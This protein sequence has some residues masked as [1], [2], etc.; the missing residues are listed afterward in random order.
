MKT[1]IA[2]A[3]L[4]L[5]VATN[6]GVDSNYW[7]IEA[8]QCEASYEHL[9]MRDEAAEAYKWSLD[10]AVQLADSWDVYQK[11]LGFAGASGDTQLW[12]GHLYRTEGKEAARTH[13]LEK[14]VENKCH[15]FVVKVGS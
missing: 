13:A 7:A 14:I 4:S 11:G 3:M 12:L 5:S 8:G 6:A 15:E 1:L 9:D 2:I 10:R